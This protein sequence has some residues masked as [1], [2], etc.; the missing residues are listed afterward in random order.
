M[1]YS[2]SLH[3]HYIHH[4]VQTGHH[5]HTDTE[6][7]N[8]RLG[9][10][11]KLGCRS[12]LDSLVVDDIVSIGNGLANSFALFDLPTPIDDREFCLLAL[13][14]CSESVKFLDAIDELFHIHT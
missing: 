4:R 7:K 14:K 1:Q 5:G 8:E 9:L 13:I 6:S 3:Q 10:A 2:K 12:P 11:R